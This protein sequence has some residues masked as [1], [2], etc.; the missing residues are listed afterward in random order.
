MPCIPSDPV[1]RVN[2]A[3]SLL[4]EISAVALLTGNCPRLQETHFLKGTP[5]PRAW[6]VANDGLE[7]GHRGLVGLSQFGTTLKGSFHL[8]SPHRPAEAS[9]AT[10]LWI[11]L[12]TQYCLLT[13]PQVY[14][15]RA[16]PSTASV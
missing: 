10:T 8:Q 2:T 13:S 3:D 14:L 16:L 12:S 4:L 5:L 11:K 1:F 15:L 6:P 7:W 9:A